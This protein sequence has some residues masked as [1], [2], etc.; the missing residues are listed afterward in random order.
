MKPRSFL[1]SFERRRRFLPGTTLL[2]PLLAAT[3][4]LALYLGLQAIDSVR[5][6]RDAA[7]S[8][9]RDYGRMAAWQFAGV[10]RDAFDDMF[11]DVVSDI[12]GRR[13][14]STESW[15]GSDAWIVSELREELRRLR[16]DCPILHDPTFVFKVEI[17]ARRATIFDT[18]ASAALLRRLA[19]ALVDHHEELSRHRYALIALPPGLLMEGGAAVAYAA[20]EEADGS[21]SL[22]G[23]ATPVEAWGE[24][25]GNWFSRSRL[26]PPAIT[27]ELPNDSLLHV[28]VSA[29]TGEPVFESA[30][31]FPTTLTA[32][33][34][35]V[36]EFG[37]FIVEA[38][39]RQDAAA[40]LI[41][42]G[43]PQSKLPLILGLLLITILVGGAALL[44]LRRERQ[45]ARLRDDFISGVSH[46][47]RTP[48]AQIRM[49]AELQ[50]AGKLR[51][52][53]DRSRAISVI[54]RESRR[55]THLVDNILRFSRLR[56]AIST[57]F[58][59]ETIDVA[60]A[61]ADLIEGFQPLAQA[62][63]MTIDARIEPGLEIVAN[64]DALNQMLLN[65]LDNAVKYG[66][67]GQ[68]IELTVARSG[69][70]AVFRIRDHGPGIPMADRR[71]IWD[72]YYR[73]VRDRDSAAPGTGI[74]L[75]VVAQLADM[76]GGSVEVVDAPG[77]GA[78]FTIRL[79]AAPASA[80]A[81]AATR[82]AAPQEVGA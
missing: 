62:R 17:D 47:L 3:V 79:P 65:L 56:Q 37:P 27:G 82:R 10:A 15:R 76:H 6:H 42:G 13:R 63:S 5:S 1:P 70:D 48:L 41:I 46:E 36:H 31:A 44:Q 34:T 4:I 35:L 20:T 45:L 23:F 54:H 11:H 71:R 61:V 26:L 55:L 32:Y 22:F 67:R 9:L 80:P 24:L 78:L 66:P 53:D 64:A 28:T 19:D 68:T 49:F 38:A 50:E 77:G 7:E 72:A 81:A 40:R 16:C 8:A 52:E 59:R 12:P 69:D 25:I 58:L 33:D 30:M 57:R 14:Q 2:V 75:A 21:I 51:S 29:P 18:D 73:L 60:A 39:V 43:L 74:G